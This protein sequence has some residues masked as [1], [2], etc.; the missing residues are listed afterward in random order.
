MSQQTRIKITR[1][2][3]VLL[4]FMI[5]ILTAIRLIFAA[6]IY[7]QVGQNNSAAS[8]AKVDLALSGSGTR[9]IAHIIA[10]SARFARLA[11][12]N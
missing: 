3:S 2:D 7:S 5:L 11:S 4:A 6:A 8:T 1:I 10:I 9:G 12:V